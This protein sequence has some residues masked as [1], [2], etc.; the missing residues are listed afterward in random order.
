V[1]LE[2]KNQRFCNK[3]EEEIICENFGNRVQL[4]RKLRLIS[5]HYLVFQEK[6]YYRVI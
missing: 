3:M 5:S 4:N 1:C 2:A 6:K